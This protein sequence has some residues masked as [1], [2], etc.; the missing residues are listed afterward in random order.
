VPKDP[1]RSFPVHQYAPSP[2]RPDVLGVKACH[3]QLLGDGSFI[4]CAPYYLFQGR[5]TSGNEPYEVPI[6]RG[7]RIFQEALSLG[8]GLMR[9]PRFVMSHAS[10]KVEILAVDDKRMYMRYHRAKDPADDGRIMVFKRDDDAYWLDDL[11]PL[12]N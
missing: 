7:W 3:A 5:P 2:R 10:G 4:G 8:S 12:E 6:V 9:R 1:Q 11:T